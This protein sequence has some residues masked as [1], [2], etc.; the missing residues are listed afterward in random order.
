MDDT[1]AKKRSNKRQD[2]KVKGFGGEGADGVEHEK[3]A[4]C[5]NQEEEFVGVVEVGGGGEHEEGEEGDSNK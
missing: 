3:D 1:K 2:L 5:S 4:G